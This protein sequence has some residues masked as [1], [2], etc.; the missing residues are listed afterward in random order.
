MP[1]TQ[2]TK[3]QAASSPA[4]DTIRQRNNN[5]DDD[6]DN[7]NDHVHANAV[8]EQGAVSTRTEPNKRV[9]CVRPRDKPLPLHCIERIKCARYDEY[10]IAEHRPFP[11]TASGA[12]TV[13]VY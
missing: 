2:N 13:I 3:C 10:D 12:A 4:D 11:F 1:H 6:Q 7:D 5:G 9:P 8:S